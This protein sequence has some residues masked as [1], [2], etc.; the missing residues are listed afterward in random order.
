MG[1]PITSFDFGKALLSRGW[2]TIQ[3]WQKE[4]CRVGCLSSFV[5]RT[6][7]QLVFTEKGHISFNVIVFQ[8]HYISFKKI[9]FVIG[10]VLDSRTFYYIELAP[11][12]SETY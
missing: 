2:N 11:H 1:S 9:Y 4:Y 5:Q 6:G 12:V 10:I 8:L 7:V 3:G